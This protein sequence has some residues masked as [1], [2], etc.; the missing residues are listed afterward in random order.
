MAVNTSRSM[1]G[2][3][4]A[5]MSEGCYRRVRPDTEV[6]PGLSNVDMREHLSDKNFDYIT[7]EIPQGQRALADGSRC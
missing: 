7:Q 1:S 5:G 2:G 6:I 3:R 4:H